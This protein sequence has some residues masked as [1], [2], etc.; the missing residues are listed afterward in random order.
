MLS[1]LYIAV[2]MDDYK[3]MIADIT[4]VFDQI[5]K[6]KDNKSNKKILDI[7]GPLFILMRDSILK[8]E[9]IILKELGY[10]LFKVQDPPHKL[11]LSHFKLLKSN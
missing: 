5:F 2:K 1:V 4:I 9:Q 7:N 11:L 8:M 3:L 10:E 6:L